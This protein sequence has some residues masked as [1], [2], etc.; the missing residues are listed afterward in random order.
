M[1]LQH[2]DGAAVAAEGKAA[3]GGNSCSCAPA[4]SF[5]KIQV[6]KFKVNLYC[7]GILEPPC[8]SFDDQKKPKSEFTVIRH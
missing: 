6:S 8:I 5:S 4:G 3:V 1:L 2:E 7:I